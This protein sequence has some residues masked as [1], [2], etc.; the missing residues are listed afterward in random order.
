MQKFAKLF[1]VRSV[2]AQAG[3]RATVI[4][5]APQRS[6]SDQSDPEFW[7]THAAVSVILHFQP[8]AQHGY[9]PGEFYEV[10]VVGPRQHGV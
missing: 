8:G 9:S 5:D 10:S 6:S 4:L 1:R 2:E 3:G 7:A